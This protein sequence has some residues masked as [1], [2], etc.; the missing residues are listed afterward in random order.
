MYARTPTATPGI[1]PNK[2][3]FPLSID[4]ESANPIELITVAPTTGIA[5]SSACSF[6]DLLDQV[7]RL[8]FIDYKAKL[9]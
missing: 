4:L 1:N 8:E 5:K 2:D 6:M 9:L 3:L 7:D